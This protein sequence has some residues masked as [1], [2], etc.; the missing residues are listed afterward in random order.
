MISN[1]RM[2]F[3]FLIAAFYTSSTQ[4]D[5]FS[6]PDG[7]TSLEFVTVGNAGNIADSRYNNHNNLH[8]GCVDYT[9]QMGKYEVTVGQYLKFLN[10]VAA[11]DP[12]CL[13]DPCMASIPSH[14]CMITQHGENGSYSYDLSARPSGTE[15]DW[16]N[17]PVNFVSFRSAAR[18]ANWLHN[19]QPTGILTGD[20]EQDAN[21][22]ENG[23]YTID[24]YSIR[25][26]RNTDAKYWI[27]NQDE[28]YKAAYHD[29][30]A[31]T[32]EQYFDFAT[33]T[34][35][36]PSNLLISPDEGNNA[37]CQDE[38]Y[39]IGD[40]YYRTPVGEFEFSE[41]PYGTFDQSGNVWEW[42][43]TEY[44]GHIMLGGAYDT[45]PAWLRASVYGYGYG[46]GGIGGIKHVGFR[47]A[48]IPEPNC[49]ILLL[50]GMVTL[51]FGHR[52]SK[53]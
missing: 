22:T 27:P 16:I 48:A 17:L 19:G 51:F 34:N 13:Y 8:N 37:N 35:A 4:G 40:P 43:D 25:A 6:M 50:T 42:T 5:V 47:I 9:F 21:F 29:K 30:N 39:T 45:E 52:F 2:I 20:T 38:A 10:A 14:G 23:A 11:S 41:S 12:Y 32:A 44:A 36:R 28:W 49:I 18:F 53:L 3:L 33:A 26:I 15:A 46:P 1:Y 31:G 7:I 24:Y